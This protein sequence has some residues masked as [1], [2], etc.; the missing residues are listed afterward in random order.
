MSFAK[1]SSLS[2]PAIS[3]QSY[4]LSLAIPES[5]ALIHTDTGPLQVDILKL[6]YT[7]FSQNYY[8][9]GL[10]ICHDDRGER[11]DVDVLPRDSF[12]PE[13]RP[14]WL[15]ALLVKY[16]PHGWNLTEGTHP[17]GTLDRR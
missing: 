13:P 12:K 15:D 6:E 4:V 2:A 5:Y 9:K 7:G 16:Q 8:L 10:A 11:V 14:V 1:S 3:H 17:I